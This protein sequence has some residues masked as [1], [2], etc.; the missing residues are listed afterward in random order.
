MVMESFSETLAGRYH[1]GEVI[2]VGGMG[3][4][5][6]ARDEVLDRLVAVK[7]LKD[8]LAG[9]GATVE[10]FRREA[11]IAA[12]LSHPG[13]CSVFDF[14]EEEGRL[15]IVM[16]LL[17]G[18]DLHA[19][20]ARQGP[21]SPAVAAGLVAQAAD[22]LDHA[23]RAGAIHRDVK[24]GNIFLTKDGRVKVTDFGIAYA[25]SQ[26]PVT[27]TGS[28][29]GTPFY[30][31]P[32]QALGEPAT[33]VVDVYSLGCV[34][35]QLVAGRPPYEGESFLAIA[36]AH[37]TDPIPSARALN[38]D[39]PEAIDAVVRRALAKEPEE[40][41]ATA[42][43]MAR[44]LRT[45]AGL[46]QPAADVI[47]LPGP[48]QPNGSPAGGAEV[49]ELRPTSRS[50]P[51]DTDPT[52]HAVADPDAETAAMAPAARALPTGAPPASTD[53]APPTGVVVIGPPTEIGPSTPPQPH[54]EIEAELRRGGR[55]ALRP[56]LAVSL[57]A[58]AILGL[59]A[60]AGMFRP[61][62]QPVLLPSW[63]GMTLDEAAAQARGLGLQVER[64]DRESERPQ[65]EVLRQDPPPHSRVQRDRPLKLTVS[66]GNLV[67][68][69]DLAGTTL[70]DATG[71]L[72]SLG[73][74]VGEV[75][76]VQGE[77]DGIVAGQSPAME[78]LVP[79]G[80]S[81]TL[82]VTQRED[83][84]DKRGKGKGRGEDD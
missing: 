21:L 82:K 12:A 50:S 35:F 74:V 34:L 55:R 3:T 9:D 27:A 51:A 44:Q 49:M 66:L 60:L 39:V 73:L 18:G 59:V 5:V 11:R 48:A 70:Q 57:L 32:E 53:G 40:R 52:L 56:L 47:D 67:R 83:R 19:L 33:P 54:P 7:L 1:L 25:A 79:R 13:I 28:L 75:D 29:L 17:D 4:V 61:G 68:V 72:R 6:R 2:G 31:S 36:R 80:A 64:V 8:E 78:T 23:H 46:P 65:G 14:G 22:A 77:R 42:A 41:F 62:D 37:L 16:E 43:E 69:P 63:V 84:D 26:A 58:M 76:E 71:L 38:P 20:I 15:F 24:P 45:A 81:I 10:R 30:V